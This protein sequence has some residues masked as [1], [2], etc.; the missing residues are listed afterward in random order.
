MARRILTGVYVLLVLAGAVVLA[1]PQLLGLQRA[2]FTAQLVSF[3]LVLAIIGVLGGLFAAV[4]AVVI[5]PARTFFVI[6]TVIALTFAGTNGVIVAVRGYDGRVV[7]AKPGE[8]TVLSWN[9]RDS[10]VRASEIAKLALAENADIVSLPETSLPLATAVAERLDAAGRPMSVHNVTFDTR[11][12]AH[13][14]SLLISTALG[15]YAR[16]QQAGSTFG[17]PSGVFT[18]VDGS[19]PTF[20]AVHPPA[21]TPRQLPLWHAG[22]AWVAAQCGAGSANTIMAGDFNSTVDHLTG[23]GQ[24]GGLGACS[25]AAAQTHAAA[26]GSWPTNVPAVLGTQIDHVMYGSDWRALSFQVITTEDAA[27]SD[28][29]PV[30]AVLAPA[31]S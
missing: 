4:L 12:L 31:H 5:R 13:S 11:D 18:P 23:L 29:R 7:A 6:A 9:T 30:V 3:R 26:I 16:N 2:Q 27:G 8:L 15:G 20:V 19:G 14:T 21:P 22:L 10:S 25:D 1:W 24:H 28:H 17:L